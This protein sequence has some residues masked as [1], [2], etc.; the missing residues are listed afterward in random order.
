MASATDAGVPSPPKSNKVI[1]THQINN[2]PTINTTKLF[3]TTKNSMD[4][5]DHPHIQIFARG[6]TKNTM[7]PP[8]QKQTK[9]THQ[10]YNGPIIKGI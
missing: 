5:Q 4:P 1:W 7:G 10:K 8:K 6:P 2:G 9:K 3:G